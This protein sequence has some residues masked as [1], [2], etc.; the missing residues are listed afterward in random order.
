M[1]LSDKIIAKIKWLRMQTESVKTRYVW[2][3]ALIVFAIVALLWAGIFR[4]YERKS[5]GGGK[6][7]EFINAGEKIKNDLENKIKMPD[8]NLPPNSPEISP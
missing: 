8:I 4:K 2:I 6:N 3:M 5:A 7:L 1:N